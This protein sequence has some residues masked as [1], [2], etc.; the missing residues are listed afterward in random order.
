MV[1]V[2]VPMDTSRTTSIGTNEM[3]QLLNGTVN[4]LLAEPKK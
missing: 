1:P 3:V 2:F 4:Q